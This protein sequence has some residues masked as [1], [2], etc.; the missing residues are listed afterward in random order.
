MGGKSGFCRK[1]GSELRP[2]A[3]FCTAC[4]QV[5]T[6][7]GGQ[8]ASL[9]EAREEGGGAAPAPATTVISPAATDPE[10]GYRPWPQLEPVQPPAEPAGAAWPQADPRAAE[11]PPGLYQRPAG[12]PAG[13]A[14]PQASPPETGPPPA[15]YDRPPRGGR[16]NRSLPLI[17]GVVVAAA[18]I[19][20]VV[21]L[22]L[23]PFGHG[24]P[25]PSAHGPTARPTSVAPSGSPSPTPSPTPSPSPTPVS[26]QQAA[27][28]LAA[29]LAQSVTDRNAVNAA[30]N[31][32]STCGPN[33]AQ[34]VQ[35][36]QR[37]AASRRQ[38]LGELTTM[39]GRAAL[40]QPMMADL[41]SAW[42]ASVRADDDFANWAQ[43]QSAGCS[44]GNHSDPHYAAA[45]EPDLQATASKRAF[46]RLWNPVAQ[47]YSL[48]VYKQGQL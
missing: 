26:A 5:A 7:A 14:R 48:T 29:L 23:H 31:D 10:P 25:A 9:S 42:Q 4:G 39:P 16:G 15:P 32:V 8:P 30:Y 43:D 28:R 34:D 27:T 40:S 1:C 18:A 21:I 37:A 22:V 35:T 17:I 24:K 13:A 33:L 3:Q 20:A 45:Y 47:T 12:E 41:T 36:F 11:P 6:P 44:T 2:G 46:I 19:A 38:L